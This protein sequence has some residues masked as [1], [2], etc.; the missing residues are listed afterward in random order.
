VPEKRE[1]LRDMCNS[2][3]DGYSRGGG[4][5]FG[6]SCVCAVRV[7]YCNRRDYAVMTEVQICEDSCCE[8]AEIH[9]RNT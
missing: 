8:G 2:A 5:S 6:L 7:A 9:C 1:C 3:C 4:V